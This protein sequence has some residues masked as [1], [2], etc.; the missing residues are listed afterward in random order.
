MCARHA[1]NNMLQRPAVTGAQLHAIAAAVG[2]EECALLRQDELG[3]DANAGPGGDFTIQV[4][5]RALG[6]VDRG[7][8]LTDARNP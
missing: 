6:E 7:W 8:T 1:I 4:I 3:Q 2:H 5:A